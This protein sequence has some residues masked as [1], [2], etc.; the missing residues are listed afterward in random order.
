M[1]EKMVALPQKIYWKAQ[2]TVR[3][4]RRQ[5]EWF[6]TGTRTRQ[7]DP[8]SPLLFIAYLERVMDHMKENNCGKRFGG[9]L[10]NNLRLANDIDLI[11][12][13]YKSLQKQVEKARAVAEQMKLIVSVGKTRAMVFDDRKIEQ[14]IQIGDKTMENIDKFKYLGS[15][16]IWDDNCSEETRRRMDKAARTMVSLRHLG[17]RKKI[18]IQNKLRILTTCVFSVLLYVWV[19]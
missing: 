13:D 11:E 7:G 12:E 1:K 15:L 5:G 8:L 18:T 2:S 16:L 10:A 19:T 9:I 4:G 3:I 6:Y 14:E 17:K